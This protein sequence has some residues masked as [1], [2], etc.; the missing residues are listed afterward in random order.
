MRIVFRQI[1]GFAGLTLVAE[2]DECQLSPEAAA[3]ARHLLDERPAARERVDP[4][5]RG[6]AS[7]AQSQTGRGA[8]TQARPPAPR[9]PAD[10]LIYEV[11]IIEHRRRVTFQFDAL[12]VPPEADALVDELREAATG[13][14]PPTMS[15]P[16]RRRGRGTN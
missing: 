2:L 14:G 6:P 12:S 9:P 11:T 7:A 15:Q 13:E 10:V 1:G 8:R 4:G 5:S 16:P 3:E